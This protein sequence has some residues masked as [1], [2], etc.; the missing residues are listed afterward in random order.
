MKIGSVPERDPQRAVKAQADDCQFFV[1]ANGAFSIK[2][3]RF[4]R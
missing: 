3:G 1:D 2:T 4:H